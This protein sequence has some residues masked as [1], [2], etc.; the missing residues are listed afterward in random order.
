MNFGQQLNT[1]HPR[2][3]QG[4][5][6]KMFKAYNKKNLKNTQGQFFKIFFLNFA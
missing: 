1:I 3:S 2:I 4:L 5:K 6:E